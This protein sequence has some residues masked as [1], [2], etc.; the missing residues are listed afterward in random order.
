MHRPNLVKY[1]P[2]FA[3][4]ACV[5]APLIAPCTLVADPPD[6]V[7]VPT[8]SPKIPALDLTEPFQYTS[9]PSA[10]CSHGDPPGRSVWWEYGGSPTL[11]TLFP[12]P[13][14][15]PFPAPKGATP[16]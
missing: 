1:A 9:C 16:E 12:A 14:S 2:Q 11:L 4:C 7:T 3:P 5:V 6:L 8:S 13:F 15:S 10:P